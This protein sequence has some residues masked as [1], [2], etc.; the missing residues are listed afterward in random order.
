MTNRHQLIHLKTNNCLIMEESQFKYC[1]HHSTHTM[2]TEEDPMLQGSKFSSNPAFRQDLNVSA[3][4]CM[5]IREVLHQK[6]QLR[7]SHAL[8]MSNPTTKKEKKRHL[9]P[10]LDHNP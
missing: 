3:V 4:N 1:N 9:P 6:K 5:R 8:R 2:T 7:Q 10:V